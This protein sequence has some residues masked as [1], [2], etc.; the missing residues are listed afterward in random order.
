MNVARLRAGYAAFVA[1]ARAGGFGPPQDGSWP[2]E[3]IAAHVARKTEL[4]IATTRAVLADD[5]VGREE[6]Q[7]AAGASQGWTRFRELT[8]SAERA[9]A[10]IRYDNSDAMDP[11]TLDRYAASGLATFAGRVER[12]AARLGDLVEPLNRGRPTAHVRIVDAGTTIV[13]AREG[14]L[15]VLNALWTRQLP[16]HPLTACTALTSTPS[17]RGHAEP[18]GA[19]EAF[20]GGGGGREPGGVGWTV[21]GVEMNV[22]ARV[23]DGDAEAFGGLFDE[24]ARRVYNHAFRLTGNWSVAEEV[25]SVTFLEAWRLRQRIDRDGGSLLPWLLGIATNVARNVRRAAR[26]HEQALARLP[27]A[28]TVPDLAES[29]SERMADAE[30]LAAVRTALAKLPLN[31]REVFALHVWAELSY[32]ETAQAL[33][34]P[35]GTVR[36]R[37]SRARKELARQVR[38]GRPGSEP[39]GGRGQ[40]VD[41]RGITI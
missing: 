17:G 34:V 11:A 20:V 2:A 36:S 39:R 22:R 18:E 4:V 29:V 3:W 7:A 23:R 1:E 8:A 5:P 31:Q 24:H 37:L 6:Q 26:R 27:P 13:D 15:G 25:L 38:E 40:V 9:A 16:L 14:W 33:G 10:D 32:A 30:E 41:E 19:G 35:V 28:E 21:L 12:L